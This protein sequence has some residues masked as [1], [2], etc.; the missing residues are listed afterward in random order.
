MWE[1]RYVFET[2][3]TQ[4]KRLFLQILLILFIPI[5]LYFLFIGIIL[6]FAQTSN[7]ETDDFLRRKSPDVI[8]V[9]TGDEGR[10]PWAMK[11]IAKNPSAKL[12]ITGVYNRNTTKALVE[13]YLGTEKNIGPE[14]IDI[15]YLANNTVENSVFTLRYLKTHREY[16]NI[17]IVSSDYHLLRIKMAMDM[18]GDKTTPFTFYYHGIESPFPEWRTFR[19]YTKEVYKFWK[20]FIFLI[21]WESDAES[22]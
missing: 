5:G 20:A 16:E 19:L 9:F 11:I 18:M 3:L 2:K 1:R 8:V 17:L 13:R 12:I 6:R 4:K 10:I 21:L 7:Q 22:A 15:D 14:Q